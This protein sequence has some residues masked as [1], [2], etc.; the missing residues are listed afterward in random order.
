MGIL[1]ESVGSL[2]QLPAP[3]RNKVSRR[4]A[5][6]GGDGRRKGKGT[7]TMDGLQFDASVLEGDGPVLSA[8]QRRRGRKW[9][10]RTTCRMATLDRRAQY[11]G[12]RLVKAY[13]LKPKL[14]HNFWVIMRRF[15]KGM[16]GVQKLAGEMLFWRGELQDQ[17]PML[18]VVRRRMRDMELMRLEAALPPV[19]AAKRE[20]GKL[21][22]RNRL[23]VREST[24]I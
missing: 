22:R 13:A 7:G 4:A 8:D 3:G 20:V 2:K 11:I 24:A 17:V 21:A 12:R 16:K 14:A 6:G 15:S 5:R 18:D 23:N 1:W 10:G 9:A 19:M